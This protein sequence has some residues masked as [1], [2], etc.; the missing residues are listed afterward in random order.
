MEQPCILA[1]VVTRLSSIALTPGLLLLS[2]HLSVLNSS[3]REQGRVGLGVLPEEKC[4]LTPH[5]SEMW[6]TVPSCGMAQRLQ[7]CFVLRG[8]DGAG[9]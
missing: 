9:V 3:S 5:C 1:R 8:T 2:R 6:H 4:F 7:K